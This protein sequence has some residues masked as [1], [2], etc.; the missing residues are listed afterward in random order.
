MRAHPMRQALMVS[1]A[2]MAALSSTV[3]AQEPAP[4]SATHDVGELAKKT[5][6]P[7]ADLVAVPFQFNFNTGGDLGDATFFNLNFQPVV[8]FKLTE[9]WNAIARTII[10]IS[11]VPGS[12]NES[13]S[14][15]GDIQEQFFITPAKPG[16][17]IWGLGPALSLPTATA[18]PLRTGTWAAGLTGV[19]VKMA[20]PWVLGG[21]VSQWWPMADAGG[22]PRTDLFLVQPFVNFNLPRGYALST[23]PTITANWDAPSGQQWTVPLGFGISKTTVFSGRPTQLGVQYYYNVKRPDGSGGQTLRLVYSLLFPTAKP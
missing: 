7:V 17:I 23:A 2:L 4:A 6:N 21:L 9:N 19:V 18:P 10:P 1:V 13:F 11:S 8:P 5:Q 22:D 16:A 3:R 14:G 20:G 12:D 15:I